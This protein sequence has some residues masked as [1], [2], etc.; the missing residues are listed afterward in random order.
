MALFKVNGH[1]ITYIEGYIEAENIRDAQQ[2]AIFGRHW[3]AS[4]NTIP[5]QELTVNYITE[6]DEISPHP[7]LKT[8][9]FHK[10]SNEE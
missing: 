8:K 7:L 3:K 5:M 9:I 4:P 2:K 6:V 1:Y 10:E